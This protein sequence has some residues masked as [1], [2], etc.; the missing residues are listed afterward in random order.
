MDKINKKKVL[1]G[2][3]S[4][5]FVMTMVFLAYTNKHNINTVS[6]YVLDKNISSID[7]LGSDTKNKILENRPFKEID[8]VKLIDG[9]GKEKARIISINFKTSGINIRQKYYIYALIFLIIEGNVIFFFYLNYI[10]YKL[11]KQ[12]TKTIMPLITINNKI[13]KDFI[14]GG[15]KIVKRK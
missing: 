12:V 7:K 10:L 8:D 15:D 14:K 9:V 5:V 4:I 11:N 6:E 3:L 2:I 13:K 1:L